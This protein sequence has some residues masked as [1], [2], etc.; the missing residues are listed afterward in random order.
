MLQTAPGVGCMHEAGRE[1]SCQ[2]CLLVVL[3]DFSQ[4]DC[5]ASRVRAGMNL[6]Y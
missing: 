2:M 6:A 5:S 4:G 1:E 3:S